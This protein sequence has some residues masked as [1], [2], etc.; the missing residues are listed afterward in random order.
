[1]PALRATSH[2]PNKGGWAV[3]VVSGGNVIAEGQHSRRGTAGEIAL[4]S[5]LDR[6]NDSRKRKTPMSSQIKTNEVGSRPSKAAKTAAK[7]SAPLLHEGARSPRPL[8]VAVEGVWLAELQAIGLQGSINTKRGMSKGPALILDSSNCHTNE[9]SRQFP[10]FQKPFGWRCTENVF[11]DELKMYRER[12]RLPDTHVPRFTA[13]SMENARKVPDMLTS[14]Q[15]PNARE[16]AQGVSRAQTA[17]HTSTST[18]ETKIAPN[19]TLSKSMVPVPDVAREAA[20]ALVRNA[21]VGP[22]VKQYLQA[23]VS[24]AEA[25]RRRLQA[26]EE[27]AAAA[28]ADVE[29]RKNELVAKLT[30]SLLKGGAKNNLT[31]LLKSLSD[32]L[33]TKPTQTA[34]KVQAPAEWSPP[35]DPRRKNTSVSNTTHSGA[36]SFGA[37]SGEHTEL[38]AVSNSLNSELCGK[39]EHPAHSQEPT[40]VQTEVKGLDGPVAAA[41]DVCMTDESKREEV[42]QE[43]PGKVWRR[44]GTRGGFNAYWREKGVKYKNHKGVHLGRFNTRKEGEAAVYKY[45]AEMKQKARTFTDGEVQTRTK[46]TSESRVLRSR[47]VVETGT[48]TPLSV[49]PTETAVKEDLP[50]KVWRAG[51]EFVAYWREEGKKYGRSNY[52]KKLGNFSTRAEAVATLLEYDASQK[53]TS[54]AADKA[55]LSSDVAKSQLDSVDAK[56]LMLSDTTPKGKPLQFSVGS[57]L[58]AQDYTGEWLPCVVKEAQE[59]FGVVE[60]RVHFTGW[61][62][63]FDEWIEIGSGRFD[64]DTSSRTSNQKSKASARRGS[65]GECPMALDN[66][67]DT[68]IQLSESTDMAIDPNGQTTGAVVSPNSPSRKRSKEVDG[69]EFDHPGRKLAAPNVNEDGED[70]ACSRCTLQNPHRSL[71]CE[72]CGTPRPR[73]IRLPD[74]VNGSWRCSC[75]IRNLP[76]A[77]LCGGCGR[78]QAQAR[79]HLAVSPSREKVSPSREKVSPTREK[80]EEQVYTCGVCERTFESNSGL[81]SHLRSA[82]HLQRV[83]GLMSISDTTPRETQLISPDCVD[84][85]T[86][87]DDRFAHAVSV[88]SSASAAWTDFIQ[89]GGPDTTGRPESAACAKANQ[90]ADPIC[91]R[92]ISELL[93]TKHVSYSWPFLE[94]VDVDGLGLADYFDIVKTPMDLGTVKAKLDNLEYS[95]TAEGQARCI[96]DIQ[97]IFDNCYLYNL[98]GSDVVKSAKKL[99][100]VFEQLTSDLPEDVI[101]AM[102]ELRVRSGRTTSRG[103][104]P[105]PV[106]RFEAGPASGRVSQT[107]SSEV[108]HNVE[109]EDVRVSNETCGICSRK[110]ITGPVCS[111]CRSYFHME[112][113]SD[114]FR[115]A[116][117]AEQD[118]WTDC[119]NCFMLKA[120]GSP[121]KC[122][123]LNHRTVSHRDCPLNKEAKLRQTAGKTSAKRNLDLEEEATTCASA[124]TSADLSALVANYNGILLGVQVGSW[125]GPSVGQL[126]ADELLTFPTQAFL[127]S[128]RVA[129]DKSAMVENAKA[130]AL[131]ALVVENESTVMQLQHQV[132]QLAKNIL[133]SHAASQVAPRLAPVDANSGQVGEV[134]VREEP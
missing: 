73:E 71:T 28:A 63:K 22:M 62:K 131:E 35:R 94:P 8:T 16:S 46:E 2:G 111:D 82:A 92:I 18:S 126:S 104:V 40:L 109:S 44:D 93:D 99:H 7:A 3:Q 128:N 115:S 69:L 20:S 123:S 33:Q 38:D 118:S 25:E 89:K 56:S 119:P 83:E 132:R 32:K 66:E 15:S 55:P 26:A 122:G 68:E 121:C 52:G 42:T 77:D 48:A 127:K 96:L 13:V 12:G 134:E 36:Q 79:Q 130:T 41:E 14:A 58:L 106:E 31:S 50:G 85:T 70:W 60:V 108:S 90:E 107:S 91:F 72:A 47:E 113:L 21:K 1:M 57:R 116:A 27:A 105:R 9:E 95:P 5:A 88:A 76:D 30:G 120:A 102:K 51:R 112:C 97:L 101:K 80:A 11:A 87:D 78:S 6:T 86:A 49:L 39:F 81:M 133:N 67:D 37:S 114:T 124:V 34:P 61:A 23:R 84:D 103:R 129:I 74:V 59:G 24:A 45:D 17:S 43:L 65:S 54:L 53:K 100:K 125:N 98:A 117:Q 75:S 4:Q 64:H 10:E 19:V 29:D 110:V